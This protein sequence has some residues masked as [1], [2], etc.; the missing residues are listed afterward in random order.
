VTPF[1][2]G[3]VG[4]RG[5]FF[6]LEGNCELN[7]MWGLREFINNQVEGLALYLRIEPSQIKGIKSLIVIKESS[8]TIC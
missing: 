4:A 2:L 8:I 5:F 6:N 7:F 1:I 3:V